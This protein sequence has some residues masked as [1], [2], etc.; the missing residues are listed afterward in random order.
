MT[1][2]SYWRRGAAALTA[3]FAL[4]LSAC[5]TP[6]AFQVSEPSARVGTVISITQDSV[7]NVHSAAGGIGGA[8]IGGGLGSLIG[9]GSGQTVATVIGAEPLDLARKIERAASLSGPRLIIALA[10][11]PTG[12]DFDPAQTVEI[13]RLAVKTGLWP[14]KEYHEGKVVHTRIP[15]PRLP[16]EAYLQTQGRY[17][18]LFAPD[19]DDGLIARIQQKVD[20]YWEGIG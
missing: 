2:V 9:G 1:R 16:V 6:P 3:A 13:G 7:Q 11:C 17:A 20:R 15:R 4:L 18:H 5:S 19:R 10:P 14:L 12:W 8:L